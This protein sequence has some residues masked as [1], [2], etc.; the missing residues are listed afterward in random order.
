ML[1][2][3]I[4]VPHWFLINMFLRVG[5][6][7]CLQALVHW[8]GF[9]AAR[10]E[11]EWCTLLWCLAAQTVAARHLS[12]CW[13]RSLP[14]HHT[15]TRALSCCDT[16][17][18]T[19]LHTQT[20]S[21]FCRLQ[22]TESHQECVCQKQQGISNIV[23]EL[24]M[25]INRMTYYISQGMVETP[26]RKGGQLCCSSVANLLQHLFVKNYQ[27]TM[28]FDIVI[29]KIKGAI[30]CLTVWYTLCSIEHFGQR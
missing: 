19:S 25:V 29:A 18:Q 3:L 24:C 8:C 22:I 16:R 9:H 7:R 6:N 15:C 26:I 20:R 14:A 1:L 28:R 4:D 23:D 5:F 10:G 30:F 13:R 17:L 27:N 2:Q 11:S 21:Q 12:S